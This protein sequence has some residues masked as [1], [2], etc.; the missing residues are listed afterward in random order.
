MVNEYIRYLSWKGFNKKVEEF[1]ELINP[2]VRPNEEQLNIIYDNS[3]NSKSINVQEFKKEK[4][5]VNIRKTKPTGNIWQVAYSNDIDFIQ[6]NKLLNELLQKDKVSYSY[7]D[8]GS[9]FGF[10][11]DGVRGFIGPIIGFGLI[12]R[13]SKVVTELGKL[14]IKYDPYFEDIGTLWFLHYNISSKPSMILWN[15]LSNKIFRKKQFSYK[16]YLDVLTD[17][18]SNYSEETFSRSRREFVLYMRAYLNTE[19][20]KLKIFTEYE[21]EKYQR[22]D[23]V[24]VPDEVL[25]AAILLFKDRFYK[26]EVTLEIKKLINYENSPGTL[27]YLNETTFRNSL[28]RL[29]KVRLINIESFADLDQIKFTNISDYVEMLKYYY[30]NK[31]ENN[32]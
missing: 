4:L 6:I 17:Q 8:I 29:R 15:R 19:L 9:L 28:E 2:A 12:E 23:L 30:Q 1:E 11:K 24:L 32:R 31:F 20:S 21:K 22:T 7:S 3:H 25:L 26:S 18:K 16:D 27:F 5:N 10:T 13:E 14:I